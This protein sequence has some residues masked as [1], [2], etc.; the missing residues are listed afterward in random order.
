MFLIVEYLQHL[1]LTETKLFQTT[2][3]LGNVCIFIGASAIAL[4]IPFSH[5][6]WP[7]LLS[8]VGSL[9]WLFVALVTRERALACY[10]VFFVIINSYAIYLR[11]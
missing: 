2:K 3:W 8:V 6:I 1:F 10:Q 7:F 11:A 4:S 5:Q 9:I